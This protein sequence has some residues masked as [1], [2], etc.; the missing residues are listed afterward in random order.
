M[1]PSLQALSDNAEMAKRNTRLIEE[2]EALLMRCQATREAPA[3]GS[4]ANKRSKKGFFPFRRY[5]PVFLFGC[6]FTQAAITPTALGPDL[7]ICS[8]Q[9]LMWVLCLAIYHELNFSCKSDVLLQPQQCSGFSS[10]SA[11]VQVCQQERASGAPG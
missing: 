10:P 2:S 8:S 9:S 6:R 3:P 7:I 5:V 4:P 11:A 1:R